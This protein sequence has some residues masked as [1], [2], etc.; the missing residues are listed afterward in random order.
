MNARI[1]KSWGFVLVINGGLFLNEVY[2]AR[3]FTFLWRQILEGKEM[4]VVTSIALSWPFLLILNLGVINL[5]FLSSFPR[6]KN[7]N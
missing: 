1:L 4:P 7:L 5:R 3:F 6:D 2:F